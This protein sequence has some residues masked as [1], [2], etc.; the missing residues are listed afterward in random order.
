MAADHAA[1]SIAKSTTRIQN[2]RTT[3]NWG[4]TR[5]LSAATMARFTTTV[6]RASG[7]TETTHPQSQSPQLHILPDSALP[8]A[9]QASQE[10]LLQTSRN[11]S[12]AWPRCF[13]RRCQL[14]SKIPSPLYLCSADS[15]HL[16]YLLPHPFYPFFVVFFFFFNLCLLLIPERRALQGEW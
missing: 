10:H 9:P 4:L 6:T 1:K 2:L 13:Y 12:L 7:M 15:F 5:L 16:T 8:L 11:D 14:T 3:T